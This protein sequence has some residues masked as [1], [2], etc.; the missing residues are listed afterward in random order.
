MF[1][2]ARWRLTLFFAGAVALILIVVGGAVF[3]TARALL[4]DQVNDDLRARAGREQTPGVA[5]ILESIR[6][7]GTPADIEIGPAFTAGG[8]FYALVSEDGR[9]VGST[10][11]V[12]PEALPDTAALTQA[13]AVG[14]SFESAK[15]TEG[16]HLRVYLV[17][18][19]TPR[20]QHFLLE[21]GRSVEPERQALGRLLF[22]LVAGGGGG[23]ALAVLGGFWL[24]GRALRP[25]Q[26]AMGQ[27]QAFVADAS[28]ELRTPLAL[29]RANAEIL[30]RESGKPV[31]ANITSVE[32]IIAET[33]RLSSLVGQMLTLAHADAEPPM[34]RVLVDLGALAVDTVRGM[35]LLA[36]PRRIALELDV[37][38]SATVSGDPTRLR[39]LVTILV[40]N[41][42]K[43]SDEGSGVRVDL[44]PANGRAV[45][46]VADRGR[47]IPP[48]ALP[49]IFDR[50]YRA[51]KGRSRGL[52]G[53]G[54]GLAIAKWIV[55][56]HDGSIAIASRAGE[57]TTA[58]VELP[59]ALRA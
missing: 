28:H 3:L 11:N 32:D 10:A 39:E 17:P 27:Q 37:N 38:G 51:D 34:Q 59:L 1:N 31:Q 35:K 57:G 24:A 49:R 15:S 8:Y 56:A 12:D 20:G 25:I 30:T 7:G 21:V 50:F 14:P 6:R 43:Y 33:D 9:L 5:R 19:E 54:L 26:Q 2:A 58:T 22:V 23:L 29:I 42:I 16:E 41:A 53:T 44:H 52:G 55:D 48:Q 47:G 18:L 45:L 13:V 46:R 40:D 36:E 4:Y